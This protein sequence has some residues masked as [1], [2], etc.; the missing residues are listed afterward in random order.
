MK[1][2]FVSIACY[3]DTDVIATC[4][5]MLEKAA[6]RDA[7]RL[8]VVLQ[9]DDLKKFEGLEHVHHH[10]QEPVQVIHRPKSWATGV[11]KARKLAF[12]QLRDEPYFFQTDCHMRFQPGWDEILLSELNACPDPS[13]S[14]ISSLPPSFII[15]TGELLTMTP[16]APEPA[17]FIEAVPV[18]DF[19]PISQKLPAPPKIAHIA[20]SVVFCTNEA[21]RASPPDP[22]YAYYGEEFSHSIRWWTNGYDMY[23]IRPCVAHHAYDYKNERETVYEQPEQ[24]M[25]HWRAMQRVTALLNLAPRETLSQVALEELDQYELGDVRTVASWE[26]EFGIDLANR[27]ILRESSRKDGVNLSDRV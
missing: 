8:V 6:N 21:A 27:R 25:R 16:F 4:C 1:K 17:K 18:S 14:V 19:K 9:T 2:I 22:F 23:A 26:A 20:A 15:A 3:E 7:L 24:I 5:D 13:R 12:D 11:G 10:G